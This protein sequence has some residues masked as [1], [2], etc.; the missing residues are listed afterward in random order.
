M[1]PADRAE[2]LKNAERWAQM[3]PQERQAWRDVVS[4]VPLWPPLP[5]ALIKPP[6]PP[7]P[8]A[9]RAATLVTNQN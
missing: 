6:M 1:S 5:T 2:F 3:S 7:T 8:R 9:P 4:N